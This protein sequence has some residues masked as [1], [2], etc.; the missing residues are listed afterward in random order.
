M[1]RYDISTPIRDRMAGFPG[2]PEVRVQP[3]HRI[4]TGSPYNLSSLT[5]SSHTGTH[6]DPPIH[7][8]PGG[9][10]I[11]AIDL[12]RLNGPALVYEVPAAARSIGPAELAGVPAH[13]ERL[14]LHSSNSARWARSEEFFPEYVALTPPGA[15][16]LRRAG[17]R[18]VGI[19]ALSIESDPSG[20]FPVHHAL[21]GHD[22][23]IIEGL[24]FGGVPPGRYELHCL[25]LRI[26][27]GDGG[28][29]RAVLTGP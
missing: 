5:L 27:H 8:V 23:L 10:A 15:E 4:E 12:D 14:L 28:P 9:A 19:D 20:T 11:D 25:P 29:A 2:D 16:A 3:V 6:V 21:L 26:V 13:T 18:L 24:R 17:V 1:A 7:F 22:V